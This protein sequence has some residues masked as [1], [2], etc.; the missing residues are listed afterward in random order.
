MMKFT[1]I[2]VNAL[3]ERIIF[4][5]NNYFNTTKYSNDSSVTQDDIMEILFEIKKIETES[6]KQTFGV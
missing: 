4:I 5:I 3:Y 2:Y 6:R 1:S